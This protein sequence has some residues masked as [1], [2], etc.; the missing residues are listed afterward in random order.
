MTPIARAVLV[1]AAAA[2]LLLASGLELAGA[3]GRGGARGGGA[4]GAV[5]AGNSL[6]GANTGAVQKR[7]RDW[8]YAF[9]DE[10]AGQ[11]RKSS[12]DRRATKASAGN[13]LR[14]AAVRT[15]P[16]VPARQAGE[17]VT[18]LPAERRELFAQ[19]KKYYYW[20]GIYYR[21]VYLAGD[22][23]Y[24]VTEAPYGASVEELPEDYTTEEIGGVTYYVVDGV[25]YRRIFRGGDVAYIV[26]RKP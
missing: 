20:A 10:Y 15:V 7:D 18:T 25:Y 2:A 26:T 9:G 4:R 1:A 6:R 11:S 24:E 14:D 12:A 16:A 17:K 13:S 23:T 5:R 21:P 8:K 22:V 19:G 3:P